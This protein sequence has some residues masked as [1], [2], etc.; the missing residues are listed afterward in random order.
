MTTPAAHEF[1][2]GIPAPPHRLRAD[3]GDALRRAELRLGRMQAVVGPAGQPA[4]QLPAVHVAGTKGK[5]STSA[6]V[7]ACSPPPDIAPGCS[8]RPT[9]IAWR[10][11]LPLMA[12]PAARS[13]F[14]TCWRKSSRR[15][16]RWTPRRRSA[17]REIGP[18]FFE[19]LT[20]AACS[21]S[22]AQKATSP[23]WR[24]AGRPARR[25]QRLPPVG[26]DH[27]QHQ[28]RPSAAIGQHV[29]G[30]RRREGRHRQTGRPRGQR[31][32]ARRA[33]GSDSRCLPAAAGAADRAGHRLRLRLPPAAKPRN[34][35]APGHMDFFYLS[36]S[37]GATASLSSSAGGSGSTAGQ[38]SSGTPGYNDL[39][40]ALVGRQQAAN[41]AVALAA[42][43]VLRRKAGTSPRRR[44]AADWPS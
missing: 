43:D 34:R 24:S 15:S 14:S 37:K 28:F 23:S 19:I 32:D 25:H 4:S 18:T 41:A 40:L 7:A 22:P 35:P 10:S 21:T 27:R 11:G 5:G 17:G 16:R 29:G 3:A 13:V 20:A 44:S 42:L 12:G 36:G 8:L 2:P 26:L 1:A 38:A 39:S 30:N 9:W 33:A 31:R 6:A